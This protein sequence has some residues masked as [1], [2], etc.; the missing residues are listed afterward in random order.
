MK[1][2]TMTAVLLSLMALGAGPATGQSGH[3]LFQQALLKERAEGELQE[4]IQ[5]YERIVQEFAAD[6]ALAARALVQIGQCWEKLGSSEAEGAYQRVVSDYADQREFVEQARARL[7]ALTQPPSASAASTIQ[8]RRLMGGHYPDSVEISGG[9]HPDGRHLVYVDWDG[10]GLAVRDLSTGDSRQITQGDWEEGYPSG[11]KVSPDGKLIAYHWYPAAAPPDDESGTMLRLVGTD[12]SGDRLLQFVGG[13]GIAP[14]SWSRDSRHIAAVMHNT[15]DLDTEIVWISVEN[16]SITPLETF[17]LPERE[18]FAGNV[19]HS[20]DDRFLAVEFPV[21][22]DSARY[23]IALVSTTGGGT[24]PLVDHPADDRLIGWVPGTDA[25]L[26]TSDRSGNRDLWA[27]RVSGPGVAGT[28]FPVRRSIGEVNSMGF[29]ADG[30]WFYSIYTLQYVKSV[31]PFDEETGAIL[32]EESEPLLGT[33]D[34]NQSAWSP[35]GEYLALAFREEGVGT[36]RG[37]FTIRVRNLGAGTERVLTREINPGTVAGPKWLPDGQSILTVGIDDE[38]ARGDW[39]TTPIGLFRIDVGTGEVTRLFD[40]PPAEGIFWFSI[41]LIPT[42]DGKGVI[43][44]H[45]G[46]LVLRDLQSGR[47]VELYRHPDLATASLALSPDGSELVFGI[48]DST[49]TKRSPQVRLNQGGRLMIMP[50]RGGQARELL[51]LGEPSSIRGVKW[52]S[53]GSHI[54]LHQRD[55]GGTALLRV[56]REGGDPERIWETQLKLSSI[57]PS[58]DGRKV[59]YMTQ[60]NEAEIWVMENLVA[61]LKEGGAGR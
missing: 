2:I 58:P 57:V 20:P 35:N 22:G 50:S 10:G 11:A 61:A 36:A 13:W 32:L 55:E 15:D 3:D 7:L 51:T 41:G 39:A 52:T 17:R 8:V 19:S 59:T 31:A 34:N 38:V 43:Y 25:V 44:I 47:E 54:L 12:G 29:A 18:R 9:P 42:A 56:S 4:A 46:R 26:F 14:G 28:P 45:D 24:L 27:V 21:E 16:G 48:A 53:D 60:T 37:G 23:D 1:R 40:F 6:R 30:S 49:V 33:H 5:L